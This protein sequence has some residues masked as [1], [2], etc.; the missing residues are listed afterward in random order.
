MSNLK[1]GNNHIICRNL[2]FEIITPNCAILR[3]MLQ[4]VFLI[5][6]FIEWLYLP[7]KTKTS[8]D[9]YCYVL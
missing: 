5:S 4:G 1:I 8:E 9:I 2:V 7:T 6:W 3:L